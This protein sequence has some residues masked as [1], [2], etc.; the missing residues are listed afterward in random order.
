MWVKPGVGRRSIQ[1]VSP[2][3]VSSRAR[4]VGDNVYREEGGIHSL[5]NR[6]GIHKRQYTY[7]QKRIS[8]FRSRIGAKLVV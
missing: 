6:D 2:K 7:P 4:G 1:S 5:P 3:T 8:L